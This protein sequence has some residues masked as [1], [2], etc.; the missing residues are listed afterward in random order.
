M[1]GCYVWNHR[2]KRLFVS[3]EV[4]APITESP[5]SRKIKQNRKKLSLDNPF[6]VPVTFRLLDA[7]EH[8]LSSPVIIGT[9]LCVAAKVSRI[10]QFEIAYR[11]SFEKF[12][13]IATAM[14]LG[15]VMLAATISRNTFEKAM[16]L[17]ADEIMPV[18]SPAGY[19]AD[20]K[21]MRETLM[22]KG[23][24]A[25]ERLPFETLFFDGSFDRGISPQ[26][27][28]P[29]RDALVMVRLAPSAVNKQPRRAVISGNTVYFYEKKA[30]GMSGNT[31][32][33]IQKIDFGIALAHFDLTMQE[34][35]QHG[36]FRSVDPGITTEEATEYIISY[37]LQEA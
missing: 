31:S 9:S 11:Y 37:T 13:F 14:G 24:K 7:A 30:K 10:P 17:K 2:S 32:L 36:K 26:Q 15:T 8:D 35:G 5:F 27:A 21:S 29:F 20:K 16:E 28:G 22:R 4:C 3:I 19:P 6:T 18:A 12:C 33:D 23:I 34:N 25:D 1:K